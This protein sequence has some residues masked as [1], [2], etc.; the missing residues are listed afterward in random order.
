MADRV[1]ADLDFRFD[2]IFVEPDVYLNLA[3]TE[4]KNDTTELAPID[5]LPNR[6]TEPRA[7]KGSVDLGV[8]AI[9]VTK[10]RPMPGRQKAKRAEVPSLFRAG[11]SWM[12]RRH[13]GGPVLQTRNN[14]L[15]D[16]YQS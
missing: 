1:P 13:N 4:W 12:F 11:A 5:V 10:Y 3:I 9:V 14:L 16:R 6:L 2:R 7:F 8:D 15:F